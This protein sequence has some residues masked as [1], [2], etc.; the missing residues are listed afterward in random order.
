MLIYIKMKDGKKSLLCPN[1][2]KFTDT[3]KEWYKEIKEYTVK[4]DKGF[5]FIPEPGP[6]NMEH[7]KT[8]CPRCNAEFENFIARDFLV[9]YDDERIKP[10]GDYWLNNEEEFKRVAKELKLKPIII[11]KG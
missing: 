10:F 2:L 4:Y 1:C 11:S 3:M 9:Y 5:N 8:I 6:C 7:L